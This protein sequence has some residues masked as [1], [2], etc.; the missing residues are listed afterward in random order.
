VTSKPFV[1]ISLAIG[2]ATLALAQNSATPD[3]SG[4]WTLNV[5]KSNLAKGSHIQSETLVIAYSGANIQFQYT[6]LGGTD[7]TMTHTVDGEEHVIKQ[8]PA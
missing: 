7:V 6:D 4:S 2:L 5:A 8:K 1:A 3:L